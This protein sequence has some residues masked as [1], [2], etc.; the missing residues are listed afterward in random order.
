MLKYIFC[1]LISFQL[2]SQVN[3]ISSC[4]DN[5]VGVSINIYTTDQ[6]IWGNYPEGLISWNITDSQD[7]I[8][9]TNSNPYAPYFLYES[10]EI[11]LNQGESYSFNTFD[12]DG[13]GSH[14][15]SEVSEP[16]DDFGMDGIKDSL[17]IELGQNYLN[18]NYFYEKGFIHY[19][20]HVKTQRTKNVNKGEKFGR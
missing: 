16:F 10:D 12:L 6:F 20:P 13:D 8:I 7:S 11:C 3:I 17:E 15:L 18:D 4:S 19:E 14:D 2:F 9:V 1:F 5:E